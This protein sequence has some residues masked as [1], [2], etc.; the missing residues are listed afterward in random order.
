[1]LGYER[2][3][4]IGRSLADITHPEDVQMTLSN[5]DAFR[6]SPRESM[7]YKKRYMHRSGRT[8][9]VSLNTALLRGEDG[10]PAYVV[11]QV[12]DIT[13]R[14]RLERQLQ[15]QHEELQQSN[16]E[17]EQFASIASHDLREP[18]R[19]VTGYLGLLQRRHADGLNDEGKELIQ[20]ADDAANR[21]AEL[22]DGIL[23]LSGVGRSE[24]TREEVD[25]ND[26]VAATMRSLQTAITEADA[27]VEVGELPTV[28]ADPR[29]LGQLFQNLLANAIKFRN[30]N[31]PMIKVSGEQLA[32][33]WR[34][35]VEDNGIGID[36]ADAE[37]VFGMFNR[38]ATRD[39]YAGTGIG[40]AVCRRI[41]ERH[42]G[43]IEVAPA[44]GGGSRFT[45][46]IA[47]TGEDA[48]P[49]R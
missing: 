13:V 6:H 42:A 3:E 7:A 8:V 34:F 38:A 39:R 2:G 26:V 11:G 40:L 44:R 10:A 36:P 9:W 27:T 45:F 31:A 28:E 29:L 20:H 12:Q 49:L 4:L 24:V 21:M 1:M 47:A 33:G 14:V 41:V 5:L 18:L 30:G 22:I 15:L 23:R 46:T 43:A 35:F 32:H 19:V 25:A 17:L 48:P 16:R 37:K